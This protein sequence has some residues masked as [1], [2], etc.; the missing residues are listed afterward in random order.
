MYRTD[1]NF[2]S[3]IYFLEKGKEALKLMKTNIPSS[4]FTHGLKPHF[5]IP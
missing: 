4:Y 1:G 5:I 3:I 2:I